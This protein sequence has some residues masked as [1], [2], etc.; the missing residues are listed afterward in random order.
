M[1]VADNK[2]KIIVILHH[3]IIEYEKSA[4]YLRKSAQGWQQ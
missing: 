4:Y 3:K 2:E 1:K